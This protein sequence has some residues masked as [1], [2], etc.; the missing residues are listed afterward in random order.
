MATSVDDNL[1]LLVV[2]E[3]GV[4]E[5]SWDNIHD[6][7]TEGVSRVSSDGFIVLEENILDETNVKKIVDI[8]DTEDVDEIEDIVR[9]NIVSILQNE[10]TDE[11]KSDEDCVKGVADIDFTPEE[12]TC[13]EMLKGTCR[14]IILC[15]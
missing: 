2:T 9:K 8:L 13:I 7:K 6:N 12:E 11:R 3:D 5:G 10:E 4:Q 1:P 15:N 14:Y